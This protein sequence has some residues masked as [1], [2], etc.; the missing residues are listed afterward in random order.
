MADGGNVD[1]VSV[2]DG[3]VSLK[4]EGQFIRAVV[5]VKTNDLGICLILSSFVLREVGVRVYPA[6]DWNLSCLACHSPTRKLTASGTGV[7]CLHPV[8]HG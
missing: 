7:L 1:I 3:V 4:L 2:E 6:W 8:G 5:K